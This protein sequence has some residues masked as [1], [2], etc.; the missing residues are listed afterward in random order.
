MN[1]IKKRYEC[2]V[3]SKSYQNRRHLYRHKNKHSLV[4]KQKYSWCHCSKEYDRKDSLTRHRK[5][6][7]NAGHR[8]GEVDHVGGMMKVA[9]RREITAGKVS[10]M[11]ILFNENLEKKRIPHTF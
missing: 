3:C 1:K 6:C 4:T 10:D 7:S 9:I 8:K 11:L 2:S 5:S